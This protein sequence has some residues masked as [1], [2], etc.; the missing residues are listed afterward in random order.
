MYQ[1]YYYQLSRALRPLCIHLHSLY[2]ITIPFYELFFLFLDWNLH[3]K[4]NLLLIW[5]SKCLKRHGAK[6]LTEVM[7]RHNIV[8][9]IT[10]LLL[11]IK[12]S[13]VMLRK[14]MLLGTWMEVVISD[15]HFGGRSI[16][17]LDPNSL[18]MCPYTPRTSWRYIRLFVR[19]LDRIAPRKERSSD[20]FQWLSK[21]RMK[22]II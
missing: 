13:L 17:L 18:W 10:P 1:S 12:V 7:L 19:R 8:A 3:S 9:C 21:V 6:P 15:S 5:K 4:Q 11:E 20:D 16:V 2:Y 14:W 22:E